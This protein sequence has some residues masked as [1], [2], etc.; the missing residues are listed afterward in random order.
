MLLR[1]ESTPPLPL[2]PALGAGADQSAAIYPDRRSFADVWV[3]R[4]PWL[5]AARRPLTVTDDLLARVVR[6]YR[7]L[8][9]RIAKAV[10]PLIGRG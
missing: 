2:D 5:H 10:K 6:L 1:S 4:R 8:R 9:H 3:A 7:N